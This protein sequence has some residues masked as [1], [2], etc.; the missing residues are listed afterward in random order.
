MEQF[1]SI[2]PVQTDRRVFL[3]RFM[4]VTAS[5]NRQ[6]SVCAL[7]HCEVVITTTKY[8]RN[9]LWSCE[10]DNIFAVWKLSEG[11]MHRIN[12]CLPCYQH[13][14]S[15]L[16]VYAEGSYQSAAW[17]SRNWL[18]PT[19]DALIHFHVEYL[20]IEHKFLFLIYLFNEA[21]YTELVKI[22]LSL[23]VTAKQLCKVT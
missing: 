14:R 4:K 15:S 1:R 20:I 13:R 21:L 19:N 2:Q 7:T 11:C 8:V 17:P 22:R 5:K 9:K 18:S 6:A 3:Q 12:L 10:Q 16:L 23:P